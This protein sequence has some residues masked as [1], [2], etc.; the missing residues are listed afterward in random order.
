VNPLSAGCPTW[1]KEVT[2]ALCRGT[3]SAAARDTTARTMGKDGKW[4]G[5]KPSTNP[6]GTRVELMES[7]R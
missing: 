5:G 4:Q 7:S 3:R 2:K 1:E 6:D